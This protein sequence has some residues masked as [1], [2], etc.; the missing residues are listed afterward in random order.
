MGPSSDIKLPC[1]CFLVYRLEVTPIL[2]TPC[3]VGVKE[4]CICQCCTSLSL[5]THTCVGGN[6][7]TNMTYIGIITSQLP[8]VGCLGLESQDILYNQRWQPAPKQTIEHIS[9]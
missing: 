5:G 6:I 9:S 2:Y 4:K 1:L 3:T 8:S 7:L